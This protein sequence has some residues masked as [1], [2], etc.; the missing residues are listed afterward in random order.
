MTEHKRVFMGIGHC[1]PSGL[2]E[3]MVRNFPNESVEHYRD[4]DEGGERNHKHYLDYGGDRN[5]S[6]GAGKHSRGCNRKRP[7]RRK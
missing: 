3:D 5:N 4:T 2:V 7:K 1:L 6:P